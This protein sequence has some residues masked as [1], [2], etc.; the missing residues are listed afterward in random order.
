MPLAINSYL[1]AGSPRDTWDVLHLGWTS[2][3]REFLDIDLPALVTGELAAEISAGLEYVHRY[4]VTDPY[5]DQ[6]L[7]QS[8]AS[9]FRLTAVPPVTCGAGAGSLLHG[10]SRLAARKRVGIVGTVYPDFPFWVGKSGGRCDTWVPSMAG[11]HPEI[12]FMERP[13]LLGEQAS[14][15]DLAALCAAANAHG[16]LVIIDESNANYYPSSF[17]AVNIVT[18]QRNLIV[19]RGLSKAYG[20]GGLRLAYCVSSN[21][22]TELV[23]SCVPPLLASSLSLRVGRRVLSEGDVGERLRARITTAKGRMLSLMAAAGLPGVQE[24]STYMPYLLLDVAT[25]PVAART[26][27]RLEAVGVMGKE[28]MY[29]D[30]SA[31]SDSGMWYRLSAPL[32]SARMES[33]ARRL[34]VG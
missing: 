13:G 21:A 32:S 27:E 24:T 10:L 25:D 30:P 34:S 15:T 14:L 29:W 9:Y 28:H 33:F 18:E 16:A 26:R 19:V 1:T 22:V 7:T 5:G 17:S 6:E 12:L 2:D 31:A 20:L 11:D 8:I 4:F 3:E 23:R